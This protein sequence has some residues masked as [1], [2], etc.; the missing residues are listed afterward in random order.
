MRIERW[1]DNNMFV[2]SEHLTVR[3]FS[4]ATLALE[5]FCQLRRLASSFPSIAERFRIFRSFF[6]LRRARQL[7]QNAD[8][9]L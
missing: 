3:G 6:H 2:R 4:D 9:I 8:S 1:V 5:E 7:Y